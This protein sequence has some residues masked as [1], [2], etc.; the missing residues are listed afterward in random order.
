MKIAL[1][2]QR[3]FEFRPFPDEHPEFVLKM[4]TLSRDTRRK[5]Q[6]DSVMFDHEGGLA[7][8]RLGTMT[9]LKIRESVY[10]WDG[11]TH[12][13]NGTEVPLPFSVDNLLDL[14]PHIR[15]KIVDKINEENKLEIEEGKA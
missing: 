6:D 2:K 5:L 9:E 3:E 13:M 10:G 11:A 8:Y 12:E 1:Q 14:P 4:R 15:S 7:S